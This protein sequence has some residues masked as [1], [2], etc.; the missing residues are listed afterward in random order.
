MGGSLNIRAAL[1][2]YS[3]STDLNSRFD[4]LEKG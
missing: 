4:L 3:K 2:Y 1:L